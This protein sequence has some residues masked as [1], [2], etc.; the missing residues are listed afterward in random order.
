MERKAFRILV[1]VLLVGG[2]PCCSNCGEDP[3]PPPPDECQAGT[4]CPCE[5]TADCPAGEMCTPGGICFAEGPDANPPDAVDMP[6]EVSQDATDQGDSLDDDIVEVIPEPTDETTDLDDAINSDLPD[7]VDDAFDAPGSNDSLYQASQLTDGRAGSL[8]LCP[9]NVD[10]WRY[11][12]AAHQTVTFFVEV[13]EAVTLERLVPGGIGEPDVVVETAVGT[14]GGFVI[15]T[16]VGSSETLYYRV[17]SESDLAVN[18]AVEITPDSFSCD[19]DLFDLGGSPN[20]S[21]TSAAYVAMDDVLLD[22]LVYCNSDGEQDWYAFDLLGQGYYLEISITF[23]AE[24]LAGSLRGA[25]YFE[26]ETSTM[27]TGS[28]LDDEYLIETSS[29]GALSHGRYYLG[30]LPSGSPQG[31]YTVSIM[32]IPLPDCIGFDSIHEPDSDEAAADALVD[33]AIVFNGAGEMIAP[34]ERDSLVMCENDAADVFPFSL[35]DEALVHF[36]I[37][38]SDPSDPINVWVYPD[39]EGP[40]EDYKIPLVGDAYSFEYFSEDASDLYLWI[41]RGEDRR[42]NAYSLDGWLS[43]CDL[44]PYEINNTADAAFD[45]DSRFV[46]DNIN[47]DVLTM[48]DDDPEDWFFRRVPSYRNQAVRI[49]NSS[50]QDLQADL[51]YAPIVRRGLRCASEDE[52]APTETCLFERGCVTPVVEGTVPAS[53]NHTLSYGTSSGGGAHVVR[54]VSTA[55]GDID[56][57]VRWALS[58]VCPADPWGDTS[59]TASDL[60]ASSGV[61]NGF[62]CNKEPTIYRDFFST[63]VLGDTQLSF[64]LQFDPGNEIELTHVDHGVVAESDSGTLSWVYRSAGDE[65]V[66]IG[67]RGIP[68]W[69][70]D[71]VVPYELTWEEQ[72]IPSGDCADDGFESNNTTSTATLVNGGVPWL[73]ERFD[74]GTNLTICGDDEDY[75][76]LT[77]L[78]GDVVVADAA[79]D[80]S[81]GD[82]NLYLYGPCD[83]GSC[84]SVI[85]SEVGAGDGEQ[86][87]YTLTEDGQYVVG[88]DSATS[89]LNQLYSFGIGVFRSCTPTGEEPNDFADQATTPTEYS[90]ISSEGV[91][92]LALCAPDAY[93]PDYDWFTYPLHMGDTF[94]VDLSFADYHGN[95]D[96]ALWRDGELVDSSTGTSDTEAIDLSVTAPGTHYIEV[97]A[98]DQEDNPYSIDIQLEQ[99][100]C[101]EDRMEPNDDSGNAPRIRPGFYTDLVRC[102]EDDDWYSVELFSGSALWIQLLAAAQ[103]ESDDLL[104]ELYRPDQPP[105]D[106]PAWLITHSGSRFDAIVTDLPEDVSGPYLIRVFQ[107]EGVELSGQIEYSLHVEVAPPGQCP[108]DAYQGNQSSEESH[109]LASVSAVAGHACATSDWYVVQGFEG[110]NIDVSMTLEEFSLDPP[111]IALYLNPDG[112]AVATSETTASIELTENAEVF[113]EVIPALTDNAYLLEVDAGAGIDVC[114]GGDDGNEHDDTPTLAKPLAGASSGL[115]CDQA[116]YY[117]FSASGDDDLQVVLYYDSGWGDPLLDLV[118]WE[119][120]EPEIFTIIG[121]ALPIGDGLLEAWATWPED[122]FA[123]LRLLPSAPE[124][125]GPYLFDFQNHEDCTSDDD[126]N[127]TIDSATSVDSGDLTGSLCPQGDVDF[128]SFSVTPGNRVE[129]MARQDTEDL[130]LR[131]YDHNQN[132]LMESNRST[133]WRQKETVWVVGGESS[134]LFLEVS[135]PTPQPAQYTLYF[136]NEEA[137][138]PSAVC[139]DAG[140]NRTMATAEEVPLDVLLR[141]ISVCSGSGNW[142]VTPVGLPVGDEL[143]ITVTRTTSEYADL[144]I[145]LF[146]ADGRMVEAAYTLQGIEVLS[147]PIVD[148]Q[149]WFRVVIDDALF[150]DDRQRESATYDLL[151]EVH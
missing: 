98:E 90:A 23:D 145:E 79:F 44:D 50:A 1:W 46:T 75:F 5:T 81:A 70:A 146:S 58:F 130:R 7:C 8:R 150:M 52:C 103:V 38:F 100:P 62:L 114:A 43:L 13:A 2:I 72:I 104:L 109:R 92:S 125:E 91:A 3:P 39:E 31:P 119:S 138:A 89:G 85:A 87:V 148:T 143:E 83:G 129:V 53:D 29:L 137:P 71:F 86:L 41:E 20:D 99:A 94:S 60:T 116:D 96:V 17:S 37:T 55:P 88:V 115:L 67:L 84:G 126:S 134:T 144:D 97:Y 102:H 118:S 65:T 122:S 57:A 24:E 22:D 68:A 95:I 112:A 74:L 105:P 135:G 32:A 117:L 34:A 76:K 139:E 25:L 108:H 101:D 47:L 111:T 113:I 33:G 35:G 59:G 149:Y 142:Y 128:Y 16:S 61:L 66:V 18:Y 147:F 140:T 26:S 131:L 40:W 21:R 82:L 56:Y 27:G 54:V 93:H 51:F 110:Q 64:S 69:W 12:S 121:S 106:N 11:V 107:R 6:V 141:T 136:V 4:Y 63:D 28:V 42:R 151:V 10:W 133:P 123:Y 48:C 78:A 80:A 127:N 77:A 15:T 30:V 14:T 36:D 73:D 132:L 124:Y 45:L 9:G 49:T 19:D 120:T